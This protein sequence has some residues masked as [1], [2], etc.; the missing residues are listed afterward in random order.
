M[1][2]ART[3]AMLSGACIVSVPGHDVERYIIDGDNGFIAQ[4]YAQARDVL[5]E[6]LADPYR[7]YRVGQRGCAYAKVVFS[8]RRYVRDWLRYLPTIGVEV[9]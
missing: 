2:G 3:E 4:S 1:P 5:R 9:A 7:A 6:L 8:S